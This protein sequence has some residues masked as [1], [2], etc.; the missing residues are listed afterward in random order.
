MPFVKGDKNINRAG[1]KV[2]TPNR[3][4]KEIRDAFQFLLETNLHNVNDWFK[5]IS[6]DDPAT[7]LKLFLSMAE[8][9][10]PKQN[11]VNLSADADADIKYTISFG[12]END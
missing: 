6:A 7:A 3:N 12:N 4:S 2:G 9:S 1:K 11:R 8:F 10:I 5:R